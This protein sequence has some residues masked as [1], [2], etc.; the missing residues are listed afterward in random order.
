MRIISLLKCV[1]TIDSG[2]TFADSRVDDALTLR[3]ET[4]GDFIIGDNGS[5]KCDVSGVVD[6]AEGAFQKDFCGSI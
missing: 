6:H 1:A 3:I 4:S 5:G 2:T